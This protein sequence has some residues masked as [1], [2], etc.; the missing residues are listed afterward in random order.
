MDSFIHIMEAN[1]LRVEDIEKV[2]ITEWEWGTTGL[3]FCHENK[4]ELREDVPFNLAYLVA[5]AAYGHH[6][7]RWH[8]SDI[9]LDPKI[10]EFMRKVEKIHTPDKSLLG[11]EV[12]A[13]DGRM[14]SQEGACTGEV[15]EIKPKQSVMRGGLEFPEE[16]TKEELLEKFAKNASKILASARVDKVMQTLLELDK[17]ADVAELMQ[18]VILEEEIPRS[19]AISAAR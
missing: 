3:P 2:R 5:C 6:P 1:G 8:D 16:E 19:G 10:R 14:F 17:L 18:M 4:L 12:I 11:T 15:C 7:S 9:Y 13:K